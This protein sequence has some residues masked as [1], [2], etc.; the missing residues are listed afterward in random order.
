MESLGGT[1]PIHSPRRLGQDRRAVSTSLVGEP[2]GGARE[3]SGRVVRGGSWN[4]NPRNA[5][6]SNRNRNDPGNRN[7]NIGFRCAQ[8]LLARSP[9]G[10]DSA[11][12]KDT[13]TAF[14]SHTSPSRPTAR[15]DAFAACAASRIAEA[16]RSVVAADLAREAGRGAVS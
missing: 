6:A 11:S 8:R 9:S 1:R 15:R 16:P 2:G 14:G 5:R 4:N 10:R 3:L 13:Q 12:F 7:N